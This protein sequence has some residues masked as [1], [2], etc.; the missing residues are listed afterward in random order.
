MNARLGGYVRPVLSR[1]S[2]DYAAHRRRRP[3]SVEPGTDYA[4]AY[5]SSVKAAEDG[6][7][8]EVKATTAGAAGRAVGIRLNDGRLVRYIHLSRIAVKAGQAVKRG[9]VIAY[10]GASANGRDW[11]VGAHL[12]VSLWSTPPMVWPDKT[13]NFEPQIGDDNDVGVVFSQVVADRQNFLNAARGE[14][15]VVDGLFGGNTRD[16]IKRYQ[17]FLRSRG[18]YAGAIDGD[19]GNGTQAG[20]E[21]YFAGWSRPTAAPAVTGRA[22]TVADLAKLSDVRGLQKIAKLYGYAG[23]ID[24]AWGPNS[25]SAFRAFLAQNYGGSLAAWLRAKWGYRDRDDIWGPNMAAAAARANTANN[26][27]L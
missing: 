5:G 9:Q 27:A 12:H 19:W 17:T 26:R 23:R 25:Q 2:S 18:W 7:V 20:H 24:N 15:L 10:S 8:V 1:I 6:S 13:I 16:A 3:P 21:R 11:G 14:K 22:A 4:C